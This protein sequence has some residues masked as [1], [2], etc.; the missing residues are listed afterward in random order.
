[1]IYL[2]DFI[3]E[4]D[5]RIVLDKKTGFFVVY[6]YGMEATFKRQSLALERPDLAVNWALIGSLEGT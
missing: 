6:Q 5:V 3:G 2:D 1:M 4:V